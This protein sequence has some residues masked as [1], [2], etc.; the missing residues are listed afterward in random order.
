MG[1]FAKSYK[2]AGI[3]ADLYS[4]KF[5][6]SP[7]VLGDVQKRAEEKK[8][9]ANEQHVV[10]RSFSGKP[11]FRQKLSNTNQKYNLGVKKNKT[12]KTLGVT[13]LISWIQ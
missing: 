12:K 2:E 5:E 7:L 13:N 9:L 10:C 4:I 11:C 6:P 3:Q 1:N 8:T